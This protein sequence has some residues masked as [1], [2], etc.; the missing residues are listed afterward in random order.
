MKNRWSTITHSPAI[1]L[2]HFIDL[3]HHRDVFEL[4]QISIAQTNVHV[5]RNPTRC[6]QKLPM[7]WRAF[8]RKNVLVPVLL[9]KPAL[10]TARRIT[11]ECT[12][13]PPMARRSPDAKCGL[14]RVPP[15]QLALHRS[16]HARNKRQHRRRRRAQETNEPSR[17][18]ITKLQQVP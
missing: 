6:D 14:M 5:S 7:P 16:C 3:W 13:H 12:S 2:L 17:C 4:Q 8:V 10:T 1:H 11:K 9:Y 18:D 15:G